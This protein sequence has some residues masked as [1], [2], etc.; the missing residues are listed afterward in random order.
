M[1]TKGKIKLE[2]LIFSSFSAIIINEKKHLKQMSFQ[3]LL[4]FI[5]SGKEH[6]R[7]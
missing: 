1:K 5:K 3:N 6:S 2:L 7:L 4:F